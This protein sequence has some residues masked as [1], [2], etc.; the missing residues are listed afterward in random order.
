MDAVEWVY[1][2]PH[3]VFE[4]QLHIFFAPL[5]S[6]KNETPIFFDREPQALKPEILQIKA[7]SAYAMFAASPK[8]RQILHAI[9]AGTVFSWEAK[10]QKEAP[11]MHVPPRAL[12]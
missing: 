6:E 11:T 5:S 10:P 12:R 2:V 9:R 7:T 3:V 8:R 4:A 1:C